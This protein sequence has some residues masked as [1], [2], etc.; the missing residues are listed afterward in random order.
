MIPFAFSGICS[1]C[2][3][4]DGSQ[5]VLWSD[6]REKCQN[7][8]ADLAVIRSA[9]ENSYIYYLAGKNT[10]GDWFAVWLGMERKADHDSEFYWVDDTAVEDNY[11]AWA[12]REPSNLGEKCGMLWGPTGNYPG[13]WNDAFCDFTRRVQE[14]KEKPLVLCQ[15][16]KS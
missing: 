6:A 3:Y 4:M 9:R 2:Y 15:K 5:E 8:G 13:E 1:E 16:P 12:T 7:M 11:S 14:G 10:P